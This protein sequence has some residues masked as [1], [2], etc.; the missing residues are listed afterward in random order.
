MGD[1]GRFPALNWCVHIKRKETPMSVVKVIELMSES[2]KSWED[3]TRAAVAKASKT[4]KGIKSVWVKDH[5]AL[6]GSDGKLKSFRVTCKV[7]F[8]IKD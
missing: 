8:E 4:V 3:A 6:V 2:D 1:L 7:S 5:S